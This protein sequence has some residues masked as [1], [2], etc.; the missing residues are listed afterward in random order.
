VFER[1]KKHSAEAC[2]I[3]LSSVSS[4]GEWDSRAPFTVHTSSQPRAPIAVLTRSTLQLSALGGFWSHVSGIEDTIR[5]ESRGPL[6]FKIG[7]GE[8]PWLQQ[9]TFS[10]WRSEKEMIQFAYHSEHHRK[11]IRNVRE[12]NWFREELYA[13]FAVTA[14]DGAWEGRA[15]TEF[16]DPAPVDQGPISSFA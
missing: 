5:D 16:L 15:L 7:L 3:Y 8:V 6:L 14:A 13:R 12:R 2:T 11:A 10:I 4:R 1:Y 9:V